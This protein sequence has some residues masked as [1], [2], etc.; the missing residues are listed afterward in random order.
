MIRISAAVGSAAPRT[1]PAITVKTT[2]PD[3]ST[4]PST[5][6]ATSS[7][8]SRKWVTAEPAEPTGWPAWS[9]PLA[10]WALSML[11]RSSVCMWIHALVQMSAPWWIATMRMVSHIAIAAA[12]R[13]VTSVSPASS[14]L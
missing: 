7:V 1:K 2:P 11:A 9:P 3:T 4:M 13:S 10:I 14:A 5:K 6:L 8:S 12:H